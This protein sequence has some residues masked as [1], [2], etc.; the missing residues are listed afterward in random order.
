MPDPTP[1]APPAPPAPPPT[2]PTPPAPPAP[3]DKPSRQDI[4]R[5]V[6]RYGSERAAIAHLLDDNLSL[7]QYRRIAKG[8]ATADDIRA[9]LPDGLVLLPKADADELAAYRALGKPDEVKTKLGDATKLQ[10][11][12]ATQKRA[13][14]LAEA[15]EATGWSAPAFV[16]LANAEN[17]HVEIR[18]ETV[19]GKPV[20]KA[21]ARKADAANDPLKPLTEYAETQLKD[22]LPALAKSDGN[23]PPAGPRVPAQRASGDPTNDKKDALAPVL[24]RYKTPGQLA[25][26]GKK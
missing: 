25:A 10:G 24:S 18:E 19:D 15:A 7:R 26:A 13:T 9:V 22:F 5:A 16:K 1:P 6:S 17:L 11:E 4:D 3:R 23:P 21:Y 8:T 20:K 2:P 12:L 14:L